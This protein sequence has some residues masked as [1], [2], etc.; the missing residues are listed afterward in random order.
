MRIEVNLTPQTI[1]LVLAFSRVSKLE[2]D[3]MGNLW[4]VWGWAINI[5]FFEVLFWTDVDLVDSHL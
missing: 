1:C 4:Q 3:N 5:L 2:N